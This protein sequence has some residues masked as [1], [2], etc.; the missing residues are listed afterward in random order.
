[1]HTTMY[2][3]TIL[4]IAVQ[5]LEHL[6]V[7]AIQ[8]VVI[9]FILQPTCKALATIELYTPY[10]YALVKVSNTRRVGFACSMKSWSS[11]LNGIGS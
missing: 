6:L 8:Q 10:A 2:N 7:I 1:M 3:L 5:K 9:M 4:Y 11:H